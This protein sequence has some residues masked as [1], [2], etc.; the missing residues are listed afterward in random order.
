MAR[1]SPKEARA[2]LSRWALVREVE[3]EELR[4]TSIETKLRQLEALFASSAV[5]G[6]DPDLSVEDRRVEDRWARVRRALS[7]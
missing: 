4:R 3:V 7:A 6:A 2:Y 1:I 5:F